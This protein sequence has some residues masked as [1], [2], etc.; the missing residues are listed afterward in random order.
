MEKIREW[1]RSFRP[2][3]QSM[4]DIIRFRILCTAVSSI[5]LFVL[6]QLGL[7]LIRSTGRVAISTGDFDFLFKSWQGPL[8]IIVG[9][10]V[11]FLYV[12]FDLN[13][14]IIYSSKLLHNEPNLFQSLKEGLLSITK[15][16]TPDGIGIILYISLIAPIVGL[17]LS[18]S[19]TKNLYIPTFIS[20]VIRSTP[21]YQTLYIILITLF[22]FFGF[23]HIFILHGILLG[24]LPVNK[25]DDESRD[26]MKKNWKNLIRQNIVFI[27]SFTA[28]NIFLFLFVLIIPL[29]ILIPI[30]KDIDSMEVFAYFVL[31]LF[32]IAFLFVNSF[33]QSFYLIRMTQLYYEYKGEKLPFIRE[34][35]GRR[36]IFNVLIVAAVIG[37]TYFLAVTIH[38]NFD[39]VFPRQVTTKIIAHRAGGNEA[40]ENTIKGIEKAI[41]LGVAGSEI[42]IQR[43]KDGYYIVNHDSTFSRL[44]KNPNKPSD[45]A[46][47]EI[48]DLVIHDPNY[49]DDPEEVA[50]FEEML[51]A[52]KGK[53]TLFIELKGDSADQKMVDDAIRMIKEKEMIDQCV[54]ISLKYSLIDYAEKTY[55]GIQTGY[56][57]FASFGKTEYISC[58]YLGLEEESATVSVISRI[59]DSER[60][61]MVWTPNEERSQRHFLLS[62][63]DYII[64][65]NV[66]QAI[67]MTKELNERI[68][69]VVFLDF[70][71]SLF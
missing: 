19:L 63:T 42:D 40:P 44:C 53:I 39:K 11:L 52:A 28:V 34:R 41:E 30:S 51:D 47:D 31:L 22:F 66:Q 15:F 13:T 49:P 5:G 23:I 3:R 9:L 1:I 58:D 4:N 20:S 60:K 61:V 65:D 6:G 21:L 29:I 43:T 68:D 46:L 35:K 59:H 54:L 16:F 32:A 62:E 18:I 10:L 57:T 33:F 45:L 69:L 17:G 38:K 24:K 70:L 2:Y 50:T 12:V 48:K 25:A 37:L 71:I 27:L 67:D 8:L 14:Q 26:L 7:L 64:T 55:P 36:W 56:L